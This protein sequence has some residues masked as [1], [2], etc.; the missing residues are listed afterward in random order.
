MRLVLL[1]SPWIALQVILRNPIELPYNFAR[2]KCRKLGAKLSIED[3]EI[4]SLT[5]QQQI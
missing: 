5:K 4:L 1:L 3:S 2:E